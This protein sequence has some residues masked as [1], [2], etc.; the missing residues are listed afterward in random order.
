[1]KEGS[2]QVQPWRP[3]TNLYNLRESEYLNTQLKAICTAPYLNVFTKANV[4]VDFLFGSEFSTALQD[5][6]D[7]ASKIYDITAL[8][9]LEEFRRLVAIKAFTSDVDTTKISRRY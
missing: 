6:A 9:A 8:Q 1:L 2:R 4:E 7:Q 5:S 3:R